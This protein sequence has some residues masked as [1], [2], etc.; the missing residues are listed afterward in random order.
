MWFAKLNFRILTAGLVLCGLT[1]LGCSNQWREAN[2]DIDPQE[3]DTYLSGLQTSGDVG[4]D[5]SS[6]F[7]SLY[8]DPNKVVFYADSRPEF[9]PLVSV[10]SII[11]YSF[12]GPTFADLYF[13]N[14]KRAAVVFV[15]VPTTTGLEC[16]L[17]I[18]VEAKDE[19]ERVTDLKFFNCT[20]A[21]IDGGEFVAE[22]ED[23]VGTTGIA[24]RSFDVYDGFFKDV[25]QLQLSD[26]DVNG[27]ERPNGK[28]STLVGFGL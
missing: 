4:N 17:M 2:F 11:D 7:Y 10:F 28:F 20:G 26:F 27:N 22:L 18:D 8:D 21:S 9:G 16:A 24:L 6:H 3:I 23:S 12:L 13:D 1:S 19:L 5:A 25:I 14:M 15:V